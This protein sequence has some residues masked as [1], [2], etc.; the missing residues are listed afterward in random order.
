[1]ATLI[2]TAKRARQLARAIASDLTLYH[3]A[4]I[5]EGIANDSLFDV[6][7]DEIEEGRELFKSR[8]TAGDLRPEHLRP[9]PGGRAR[10]VQGAREVEDLVAGWFAEPEGR[11]RRGG[12]RVAA[13][14]APTA[15]PR[16]RR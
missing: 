15:A 13:R 12:R 7:R 1:M 3:E 10:E 5:L 4:K 14:R 6:M 9:R 11:R 16:S 2:E 8:V